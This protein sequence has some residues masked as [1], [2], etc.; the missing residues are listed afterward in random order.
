MTFRA[1]QGFLIVRRDIEYSGVFC[2]DCAL[3][4]Y[5]KA[6]GVTLAG[7]WFSP[8]SLVMGTLGSLWDSAKLLD[9]PPE[10]KDEPWV[11]HKV[12][13]PKCKHGHFMSAGAGDCEKCRSRFAVLSCESCGTIVVHCTTASL[14]EVTVRC[15]ACSHV[16][17]SPSPARN[18][19]VLLFPRAL[20]EVAS[21]VG[22][23]DAEFGQWCIAIAEQSGLQP[24]SWTWLYEYYRGCCEQA[25]VGEVLQ[26]CVRFRQ[27]EFLAVVLMVCQR[28]TTAHQFANL[29]ALVQSL[30]LDPDQIFAA[31]ADRGPPASDEVDWRAVLGVAVGATLED[32]QI[33]YR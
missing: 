30:G 27:F 19:P 12:D 28:L 31:R 1:H 21:K 2:R 32:V 9:L 6:R 25:E 7:M 29:R 23:S 5:A 16:S 10:V 26:N 24:A 14:E 33:A 4:V 17:N 22:T 8:G 3:A 18:A 13:C 15:R 11:P 20:A